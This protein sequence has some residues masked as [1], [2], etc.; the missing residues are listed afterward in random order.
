MEMAKTLGQ[1]VRTRMKTVM[2]F[3]GPYFRKT[4]ALLL[5]WLLTS[6]QG[7]SQTQDSRLEQLAES[8]HQKPLFTLESITWVG[9]RIRVTGWAHLKGC[10]SQEEEVYLVLSRGV[11]KPFIYPSKKI[12]RLDVAKFFSNPE[13]DHAGFEVLV[14]AAS[15]KDDFYLI[16]I[17]T[18]CKGSVGYAASDKVL[19]R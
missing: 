2:R 18:Q 17:L 14:P 7:Q 11:G 10:P 4:T 16:G 6:I 9:N 13:F 1:E 8:S 5:L 15:L 3:S 19:H 12:L